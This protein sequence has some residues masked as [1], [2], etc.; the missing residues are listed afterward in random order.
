MLV[1]MAK[2]IISL[3]PYVQGEIT[4]KIRELTIT[5]KIIRMCFGGLDKGVSS[6]YISHVIYLKKSWCNR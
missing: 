5:S 4:L 2:S 3:Q 6:G 1:Q